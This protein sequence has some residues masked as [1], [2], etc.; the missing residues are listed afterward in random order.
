MVDGALLGGGCGRGMRAGDAG[1]SILKNEQNNFWD[2]K[3]NAH[4]AI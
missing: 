1:Y 4:A 3:S 2:H